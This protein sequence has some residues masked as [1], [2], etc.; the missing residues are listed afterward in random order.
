MYKILE[1]RGYLIDKS[2]VSD[3]VLKQIKDELTVSPKQQ[4]DYGGT[5]ESFPIYLENKRKIA[6]PRFYGIK[7]F[8]PPDEVLDLG[9]EN[10]PNLVFNGTLRPYQVE[11]VNCVLDGIRSNGGGVLSVPCGFG[12]TILA[13]YIACQLRLKTAVLVHKTFLMDQWMERI[14]FVCGE[15]VRI[16]RVQQNRIEVEGMDVV[17]IMIQSVSLKS[18]PKD[19]F[20][21]I[22]FLIADECHHLG[23]KVFSRSLQKVTAQYFLGLS[24]TPKR[25]D[26]MSKVFHWYLGDMLYQKAANQNKSVRVKIF[27]YTSTDPKF[28]DIYIPYNRKPNASKMI[29]NITEID[30]R[31]Q[32]I[33]DLLYHIYQ[34][35]PERQTL[36]LSGRLD[37]LA[38]LKGT[39]DEMG[40]CSTAYYIGKMKKKERKE[41]EDKKVLFGTYAMACV[42]D[43]TV[44]VDPMTGEEGEI[45][46]M[47]PG[48]LTGYNEISGQFEV[49][50]VGRFGYTKDKPC[51]KIVHALGEIVVS[52]DH[53]MYT[54]EGWVEAKNLS[55]D[56]YLVRPRKIQVEGQDWGGS[57]RDLWVLGTILAKADNLERDLMLLP[58]ERLG[59]LLGG[60]FDSCGNADQ[61]MYVGLNLHLTNQVIFLLN[62]LGIQARKVEDNEFN[63][64]I[65][66]SVNEFKRQI[67]CQAE[68]ASRAVELNEYNQIPTYLFDEEHQ[69]LV[70]TYQEYVEWC[71]ENNQENRFSKVCFVEIISVEP[72]EQAVRLCDLEMPRNHSF[73]AEGVLVHNSEGL[74]IDGLN[75]LF[76]TTPRTKVTQSVG[77]ILRKENYDVSPLVIDFADQLATFRNQAM[78]RRKFF[79]GKAYQ[80]Q[81]Y[82]ANDDGLQH[83]SVE[84]A[85]QIEDYEEEE[86]EPDS[87]DENAGD[88]F[89][90]SDDD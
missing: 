86:S 50:S 66:D 46:K 10:A 23:S 47:L 49:E 13:I 63:V 90:D 59:Y 8:G 18:Y 42:S 85:V 80:I 29:T 36:I 17:L 35:E 71:L 27:S 76:L 64:Q 39:V 9:V 3:E 7:K 55:I 43:R 51:Y 72:Y 34:M 68:I 24:A 33:I 4:M 83:I 82:S 14:R 6:I 81:S 61:V 21:G 25:D 60:L 65:V 74:D 12:K 54:P 79:K 75:T 16:G 78:K 48:H 87:E 1:K 26:G 89:V 22:G 70:V 15:S 67:K 20:D 37:H 38:L 28:K 11:A 5:P 69:E 84:D 53:E 41:A 77:R 32:L 62:R 57:D 45:G 44:L 19:T 31:N 88:M 73:M 40:F 58:D 30:S 56:G 2:T 52:G